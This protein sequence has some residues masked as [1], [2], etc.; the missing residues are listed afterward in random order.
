MWL[1]IAACHQDIVEQASSEEVLWSKGELERP[2]L[3]NEAEEI[4]GHD[5]LEG[6]V[7][8]WFGEV[9]EVQPAVGFTEGAL[10]FYLFELYADGHEE[11]I[12]GYFSRLM[13]LSVEESCDVCLFAF[14]VDVAP[15]IGEGELTACE[16]LASDLHS[17]QEQEV[18]LGYGAEAFY[19]SFEGSELWERRGAAEWNEEAQELIFF[20]ETELMMGNE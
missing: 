4:E 6:Y 15:F 16:A 19:L 7:Y 14:D 17:F 11:F 13:F 9:F 20:D 3:L 18:A 8:G 1:L 5:E 10:E 2:S 12:C